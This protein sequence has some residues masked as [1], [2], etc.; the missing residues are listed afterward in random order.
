METNK[1]ENKAD[2]LFTAEIHIEKG[3]CEFNLNIFID[4]V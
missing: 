3:G 4:A 1:I 2:F